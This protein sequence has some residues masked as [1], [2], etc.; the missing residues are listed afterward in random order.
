MHFWSP[1]KQTIPHSHLPF[2]KS[3]SPQPSLQSGVIR[4]PANASR[5]LCCWRCL[6]IIMTATE[7]DTPNV[8]LGPP[9]INIDPDKHLE[10]LHM[11]LP[12]N[13]QP[14]TPSTTPEAV[15][16]VPRALTDL[17]DYKKPGLYKKCSGPVERRRPVGKEDK[18]YS[19]TGTVTLALVVSCVVCS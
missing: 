12:R 13:V 11:A 4:V 3:D 16:R 9:Q 2:W 1:L 8:A 14:P 19:R 5:L 10:E 15:K 17:F 18:Q 7:C 6:F